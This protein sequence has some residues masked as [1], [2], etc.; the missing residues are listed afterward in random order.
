MKPLE[1]WKPQ[2]P[3]DRDIVLACKEVILSLLPGSEIILYGS[4]ARGRAKPESDY[5]FLVLTPEPL[6]LESKKRLNSS[7][8]EFELQQDCMVSTLVRD[9]RLWSQPIYQAIPLRK[10]VQR[11]GVIL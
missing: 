7:L 4:R 6:S 9:R 10:R 8:C 5:D 1:K 2:S 3:R 11:D